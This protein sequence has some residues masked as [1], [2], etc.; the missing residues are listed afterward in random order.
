MHTK[1]NMLRYSSIS[2]SQVTKKESLPHYRQY[3]KDSADYSYLHPVNIADIWL[4]STLH[5]YQSCLHPSVQQRIDSKMNLVFA[6]LDL[7]QFSREE[8]KDII[9]EEPTR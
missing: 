9:Y 7:D 4:E 1:D 5:G 2:L 6:E 3:S 8:K